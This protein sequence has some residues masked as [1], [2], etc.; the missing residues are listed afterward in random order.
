MTHGWQPT[1]EQQS[2]IYREVYAET[3]DDN[4]GERRDEGGEN[5]ED[6]RP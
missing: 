5:A 2:E 3:A 4:D 1:K 6:W